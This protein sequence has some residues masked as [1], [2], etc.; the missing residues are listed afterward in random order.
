GEAGDGLDVAL[1]D[2]LLAEG[3]E[4]EE[5]AR[6]AE[7][8]GQ[9]ARREEGRDQAGHEARRDL[10]DARVEIAGDVFAVLVG[11]LAERL[12]AL[13]RAHAPE[14]LRQPAPALEGL[15]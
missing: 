11:E 9:R 15:L 2:D 5:R 8:A 6:L 12:F 13:A 1:D 3:V 4:L 10:E 7:H 14:P